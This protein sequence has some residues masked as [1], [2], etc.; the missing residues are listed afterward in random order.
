[1]I[2]KLCYIGGTSKNKVSVHDVLSG[3]R[4]T[5][6]AKKED[7]NVL[8]TNNRRVQFLPCLKAGVS[9]HNLG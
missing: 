1:M 9:M 6:N 7:L 8:Y 2:G 4:I 5:Q 3:N